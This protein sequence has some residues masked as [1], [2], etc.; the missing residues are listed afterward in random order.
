MAK[1]ETLLDHKVT[2]YE[3][4]KLTGFEWHE[5][6]EYIEI[7]KSNNVGGDFR[8]IAD[9]YLSRGDFQKALEYEKREENSP[10][11]PYD[12]TWDILLF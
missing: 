4:R 1:F 10:L 5:R 11:V 7:I 12:A 9:L 8:N 6:F 3:L 2:P